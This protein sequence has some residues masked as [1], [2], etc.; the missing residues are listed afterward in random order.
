MSK[1]HHQAK[2]KPS[3]FVQKSKHAQLIDRAEWNL[4]VGNGTI[5]GVISLA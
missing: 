3:L 5:V 4:L 2:K 1:Y